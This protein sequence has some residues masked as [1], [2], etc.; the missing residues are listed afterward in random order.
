MK[1]IVPFLV[2]LAMA[3]SAAGITKC[4][5]SNIVFIMSDDQDR[6]LGSLSY[7]PILQRELVGKGVEFENH[8]GTVSNCCPSRASLLRGQAAHSTNIT[9]VRPPG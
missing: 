7:M 5:K 6:Q 1:S 3:S 8:F 2:A 9:H 4:Q